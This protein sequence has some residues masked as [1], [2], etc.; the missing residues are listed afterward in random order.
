MSLFKEMYLACKAAEEEFRSNERLLQ[1][2]LDCAN[3]ERAEIIKLLSNPD[4]SPE[5]A[6]NRLR[7]Y[8]SIKT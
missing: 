4:V 5:D 7:M 8:Y 6:V 2:Q 1:M 3:A